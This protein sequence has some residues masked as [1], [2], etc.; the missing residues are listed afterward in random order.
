MSF[1][2]TRNHIYIALVIVLA[3]AIA[4][5]AYWSTQKPADK[6][7][8]A[9]TSQPDGPDKTQIPSSTGPSSSADVPQ[10]KDVTVAI[11]R[12]EEKDD[13]VTLEGSV[14]GATDGDCVVEFTTPNDKPVIREVKAI[15]S[16]DAGATCGP[17]VIPAVQFAY[18]GDWLV[19]LKL[20]TGG[21][22]AS[23]PARTITIQ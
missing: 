23:S 8:P 3:L 9:S 18:L 4:G 17:I 13:K 5:L 20:Y 11:T 10:K 19:V 2:L 7:A 22:Q 12:L 21:G 6:T 1:K 16:T 15:K 14:K